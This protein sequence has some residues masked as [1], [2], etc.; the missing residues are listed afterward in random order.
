MEKALDALTAEERLVLERF[1][2]N[3]HKGSVDRLCEELGVER[4]AVYKRKDA[5]RERF[6]KLLY[7][8]V[9]T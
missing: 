5:A 2:I 4:T 8:A 9:S 3:P 6:T 7:G 1:Y